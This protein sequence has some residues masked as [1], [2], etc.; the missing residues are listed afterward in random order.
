MF[1]FLVETAN[2]YERPFPSQKTAGV[3][4]GEI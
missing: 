1:G 4:F 3:F 2:Q